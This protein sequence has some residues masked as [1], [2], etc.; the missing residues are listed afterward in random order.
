[1]RRSAN[2]H[3]ATENEER[4]EQTKHLGERQVRPLTIA[5]VVL[6]ASGGAVM[7][8][9]EEELNVAGAQLQLLSSCAG[10]PKCL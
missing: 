3:E 7:A 5:A 9:G 8:A 10:P 1:M 2:T 4:S 6:T